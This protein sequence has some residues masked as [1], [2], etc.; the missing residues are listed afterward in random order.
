[1]ETM[2]ILG[3]IFGMSALSFTIMMK[4]RVEDLEKAL[5]DLRQNLKSSGVI[6]IQQQESE[7]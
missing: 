2:G 4:Q 7:S 6:Q 1:M 3:F 5:D